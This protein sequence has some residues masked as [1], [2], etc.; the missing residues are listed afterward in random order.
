MQQKKQQ[1]VQDAEWAAEKQVEKYRLEAVLTDYL[2]RKNLKPGSIDNYRI[3]A[4]A[5]LSDWKH[6]RLTDITKD[7]I[8]NRF[9][10][11][12]NRKIGRGKGGPGAN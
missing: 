4:N 3:V 7:D 5:Y 8:E 2:E 9:K 12:T 1:K 10:Q 11:I 6:R